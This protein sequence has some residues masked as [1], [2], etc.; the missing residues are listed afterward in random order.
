[1]EKRAEKVSDIVER[2]AVGLAESG[3]VPIPELVRALERAA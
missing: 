2:L 1:M 3:A